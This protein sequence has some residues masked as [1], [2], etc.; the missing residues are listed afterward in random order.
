MTKKKPYSRISRIPSQ[1][2][3]KEC[4]LGTSPKTDLY[5]NIDRL[6]HGIMARMTYGISPSSLSMAYW[7]WIT[8]L[9]YSPGKKMELLHDF[10]NTSVR[11]TISASEAITTPEKE[12]PYAPIPNDHRFQNSKWK[13]LPFRLY[14]QAFLLTEGW[15][16]NATT[17]VD[18]V[19]GHHEQVVSFVTRQLLDMVAPSNFILTN[20]VVLHKT[21]EC[22]GRNLVK[23][24]KNAIEDIHHTL[25]NA[26]PIGTEAYQPGVTVAITPGQVIYRNE[27]IELI[28]YRPTTELVHAEPILIIPA[29]IM[30][31]YILDL[32]PHNSL[33]KYL[34]DQGHT[35]FMIS[36]RNPDNRDRNLGMDDYL[37]LG[38]LSAI[39]V[40]EDIIPDQKINA[41]GYC[42][43]GTL[44][45]IAAAYLARKDRG[46]LN[47]LTFLATQTDFSEAGELSI[48]ID[49]SQVHFLD[50]FMWAQGYLDARQMAG[51]FQILKSND[52]I[53][54]KLIHHY[55]SGERP[56]VSDLMAWSTDA[57]RMPYRMHIEYLKELFLNNNLFEG[58]YI[59]EG[60]PVVLTDIDVPIFSVGTET[61]HVAPW[62]S[63]YKL[64]MV[65]NSETTFIL[66]SGGHNAGIVNEPGHTKH[67]YRKG[68]F[69]TKYTD[70]DTWFNQAEILEGS[71]WLE[72]AT[73]LRER[74]Q[75]EKVPPPPMGCL[76]KGHVPL[77]P[78]PGNYVL[79]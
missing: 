78:A 66:T 23:G 57:T 68:V 16:Q 45:A 60:V 41:M 22:G 4:A 13:D 17:N 1:S 40:I 32:S 19:S 70:P 53:W 44:L 50:D 69:G 21:K 48:F 33:V 64:N 34:I 18:G 74:D 24:L 3:S 7:D 27:L 31:Y 36:W 29:W 10:L 14:Y 67:H 35:V 79:G 6:A 76:A 73:W 11:Y 5:R 59:V 52:L 42:I 30:K 61:D 51:I 72:W 56:P 77:M 47:S 15:W 25:I 26:R 43:G 54:S 63:V 28:Q 75:R 65:T 38:I 9:N 8:H 2:S 46:H 71:W 37:N 49:D 58:N 62:H 55:L 20:P 12:C 39:K